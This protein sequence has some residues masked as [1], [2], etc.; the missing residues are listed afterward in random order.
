MVAETVDD[1]HFFYLY[2]SLKNIVQMKFTSLNSIVVV[3]ISLRFFFVGAEELLIVPTVWYY[4]E[5]LDES[6]VFLGLTV[7]SY[8][9]G[10]VIF[11]QFIGVLDVKLQR[12]SKKIIIFGSL[13]KLLGNLL[14]SIPVNGYFPLFG[15]FISGL[16]ESTAPVLYGAIAKCSTN[17]NRAK[18]FLFFEAI[19]FI[20]HVW[21]SNW[22]LAYIQRK[23]IRLANQRRKFTSS[24]TGDYL[25]FLACSHHVPTK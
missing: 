15:R 14:Y 22:G 1:A 5:Y 9:T 11:A 23:Y 20:G 4:M 25:V 13:L 2:R 8:S 24:C 3:F 19:Y 6:Y 10:T 7:A 17:E 21:A 16:G 18:V 12:S